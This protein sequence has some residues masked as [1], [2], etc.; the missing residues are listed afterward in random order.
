MR[1]V[2]RRPYAVAGIVVVILAATGSLVYARRN[3]SDVQ[4]RTATATLGTVTQ[5]VSLSGNLTPVG[6][7]AL[8]FGVAG[9]VQAVDVAPGQSVQAGQVLASLD[10]TSLQG[11]L[12]QAQATMESAQAKL[13]L[14]EGG[15]TPQSL[16]QA[17]GAVGTAQVQL[18]NAQVSLADTQAANQQATVQA[19]SAVGAAQASVDADG[20]VIAADA[21][22]LRSDQASQSRDCAIQPP[23]SACVT[24]QQAVA[25][26]NQRV[27][28]DGQTLT[29][30]QGSLTAAQ[31][32]LAAAQVKAQQTNDASAGQVSAA[33]VGL[34]NAQNA[35]SAL[36]EGATPEQIQMDQSQLRIDQVNLDAA[37]RALGEA[38]L[39]A[40][41]A[42]IAGEVNVSPGQSVSGS[43]GSGSS[44]S[45]ASGSGAA[46]GASGGGGAAGSP[47]S[48]SSGSSTASSTHA[49]V[50]L[51]PGALQVT[52]TVTDAQVNQMAIGQRA[53]VTPAGSTEAA[54]GRVTAVAPEATVS[55]GVATFSVT[56][57]LDGASPSLRAG[58]SASIAVIV[59][60]V[61]QVLTVPTSAVRNGAGGSSVQLLVD[62]QPQTRAVQ[63]GASDP[64][65]TQIVSGLSG[66]DNVVVA[67]VT[68]AVPTGNAGGG[69]GGLVFGGPGGGGSRGGAGGTGGRGGAAGAG[70]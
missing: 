32:S 36:Q 50:L 16:A 26:D 8:D 17:Q 2:L 37:T 59:N 61:V 69:G 20:T 42:G 54:T 40:P 57:T 47:S 28:A 27:A 23:T 6:A 11:T 46:S 67:T 51:T 53:R 38:T 4:Y 52:G 34:R 63:V 5:T 58:T 10:S 44:G 62:G 66:G 49:I 21:S 43:S 7:T 65:R 41:V 39:T 29:R 31:N 14:D 56:V 68:G 19:Q 22:R 24:D 1:K 33:Q 12:A 25:A 35:L 55:S 3:G 60:Q 9:R 30:D 45:G 15:V 64:L 18:Q 70:G 13:S 48:S